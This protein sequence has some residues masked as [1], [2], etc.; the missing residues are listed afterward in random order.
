M[1]SGSRRFQPLFGFLAH[2]IA[3]APNRGPLDGLPAQARVEVL[4][5]AAAYLPYYEEAEVGGFGGWVGG[6]GRG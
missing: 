1:Q 3:L 2:S 5:V 6:V 4:K